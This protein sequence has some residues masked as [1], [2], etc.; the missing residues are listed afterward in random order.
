[1]HKERPVLFSA[2]MVQAILGGRK[3]Q[4]RRICKPANDW[5]L[6]FITVSDADGMV[7]KTDA[8]MTLWGDEEGEIAFTCPY[9][10]P[11]DRLWVK[12]TW[13]VSRQ[14]DG[15]KPSLITAGTAIHY[16]ADGRESGISGKN[17]PSIFM[18][19]WASR[20]ALEIK[21]IRIERLQD[22]SETDAV[23]EGIQ[24]AKNP[25]CTGYHSYELNHALYAKASESYGSLWRFI[26]GKASWEENPWVWVIGF[27][28]LE[29]NR[30][31][32]NV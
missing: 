3:T 26:N 27:Q 10:V 7:P 11:G 25:T 17:R 32:G 18:P 21:S 22:I 4:T 9:G 14:W 12:E 23:A 31:R 13:R 16:L 28:V 24:H 20:I 30:S 29:F 8:N 19:R 15:V 2:D 6:S 1:M 5:G